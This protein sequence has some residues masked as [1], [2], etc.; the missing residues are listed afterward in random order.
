MAQASS[1]RVARVI[2]RP[3]A[4]AKVG[5][6]VI[7]NA[8]I[9]LL[10]TRSPEA[11]TVLEVAKAAG[12]ARTLVRYYFGDLNGLLREVAEQLMQ[13]LQ[14]SMEA[15][16][17]RGRTLHQ[18]IRQRLL[19]RLNFMREHPHFEALVLSEI[20]YR[21]NEDA[22]SDDDRRREAG[23][24]PLSRVVTR[25]MQLTLMLFDDDQRK[26]IDPRFIHLAI[27][28]VSAFLVTGR[29]LVDILLGTGTAGSQQLDLYIN[30]IAKTLADCI[31]SGRHRPCAHVSSR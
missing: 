19:L 20:Y 13:Q 26:S 30:F 9:L 16:A 18:R 3:N 25:G 11:L 1:R 14:D 29:P 7:I 2:G 5:R 15:A 4:G 28:S 8:A 21:S 23:E 22:A 31:E 6:Q 27:I 17:L 24:S 10:Q 12:V